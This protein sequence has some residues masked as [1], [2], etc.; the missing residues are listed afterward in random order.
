MPGVDATPAVAPKQPE[1]KV[2]AESRDPGAT[3]SRLHCT[4]GAGPDTSV[5]QVP[6][7]ETGVIFHG[8]CLWT[9]LQAPSFGQVSSE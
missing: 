1:S 9:G 6:S 3:A 5:W 7:W 2:G 4:A 8:S